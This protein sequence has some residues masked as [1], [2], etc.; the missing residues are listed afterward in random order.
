MYHRNPNIISETQ[1]PGLK[2]SLG[3]Y[4][5]GTNR[6]LHFSPDLGNPFLKLILGVK[7][8]NELLF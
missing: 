3:I 4:N 1:V 7:K 5:N 8:K 6:S 2:I